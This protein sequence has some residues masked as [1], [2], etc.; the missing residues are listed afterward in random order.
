MSDDREHLDFLSIADGPLAGRRF[1]VQPGGSTVG[2]DATADVVLSDDGVSRRHAQVGREARGVVVRDLGSTNG[3]WVN[4]VRLA[5]PRV[6]RPGDEVRVGGTVLRLESGHQSEMSWA[7]GTRRGVSPGRVAW[8]GGLVYLL[9]SLV[10]FA[11]QW[12]TDLT[13]LGIWIAVP[14]GALGAA[15]LEVL[16]EALHRGARL[17]AEGP[18]SQ[19][20][21]EDEHWNAERRDEAPRGGRPGRSVPAAVAVAAALLVVGGGGLAAAVGIGTLS[22]YVTGNERGR[23]RL[24]GES[25]DTAKGIRT[26]VTSVEQT[27]NFTRVTLTVRNGLKNSITLSLYRNATLSSQ[28]GATLE[29]DSFRSTWAET[30]AEGQTRGGV[31]VFPGALPADADRATL[32]FASVFEMGFDGPDSIVVDLVL[33]P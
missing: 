23:E 27:H 7:S 3:T 10:T 6:L 16:R 26:V 21:G 9:L 20:D 12:L 22:A 8:V 11:I 13:G 17:P 4:G 29:A 2:R 24:I 1:A 14:V 18:G 32:A 25:V 15:L 28:A 5:A 30:I 31:I 33:G 19:V